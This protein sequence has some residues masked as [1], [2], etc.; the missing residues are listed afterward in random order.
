MTESR[1]KLLLGVMTSITIMLTIIGFYFVFLQ[2]GSS[3]QLEVELGEG[4]SIKIDLHESNKATIDVVLNTLFADEKSAKLTRTI[5]KEYHHLH[6]L[7][8]QLVD[9]IRNVNP[10]SA[11]SSSLRR[12]LS[13]QEG[14]FQREFHSYYDVR[15]TDVIAGLKQNGKEHE[16]SSQLRLMARDS[17]PPIFSS[18]SL[19]VQVSFPVATQI[20][21]GFA[22]TCNGSDLIGRNVV[23]R[24]PGN[25]AMIQVFVRNTFPCEGAGNRVQLTPS[26]AN[27]LF[28]DRPRKEYE[29]ADMTVAQP[30]MKFDIVPISI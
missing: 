26:D 16:V 18:E 2:G 27:N 28:G 3:A 22:A 21:E 9:S 11:F 12:L 10:R 20:R 23:L 19:S 1:L 8:S 17:V 24:N 25:G 30:G 15:T 7:D 6:E 4:K 5:L 13:N 29:T 14:P